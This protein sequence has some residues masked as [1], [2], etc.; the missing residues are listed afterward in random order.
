MNDRGLELVHGEIDGRLG[1]AERAELSRL[2][3]ADPRLRALREDL[4]RT[5]EALDAVPLEDLPP[6]LHD[7]I[8]GSL[9]AAAIDCAPSREPGA[10]RAPWLRYAAAF[11]SGALV[12]V[13]GF[14]LTDGSWHAVDATE[15][16]GTINRAR[17]TA[18][19]Q[20][21]HPGVEGTVALRDRGRP[22]LVARLSARQPVQVVAR[23]GGETVRLEGFVAAQDVF[24]ELSASFPAGAP[25][26]GVSVEVL[27]VAGN[28]LQSGML[29][30]RGME[31]K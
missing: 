24:V 23:A 12:T 18:E 19:L 20:V 30:A 27:D 10:V 14:Q 25:A 31:S 5:C 28:R 13:L 22:V 2:L 4:R 11:A 6:G 7:S 9:T 3:L 17:H 8:L 15:V 26:A 29:Q 1:S 16:A 21:D